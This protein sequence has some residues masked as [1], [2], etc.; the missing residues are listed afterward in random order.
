M[1]SR[2]ESGL[3]LFH[4]RLK[5]CWVVDGHFRKLLSIET[6]FSFLQAVDKLAVAKAVL[7][8]SGADSD[9][10]KSSELAFL[11]ATISIGE[12][13]GASQRLFSRSQ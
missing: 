10:P 6:D 2:F 8:T 13:A 1:L 12:R 5:A 11:D 3:R 9:N 7:F 4:D